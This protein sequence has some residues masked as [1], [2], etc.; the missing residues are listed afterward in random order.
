MVSFEPFSPVN[1]R[2]SGVSG[3]VARQTPDPTMKTGT[4]T[5]PSSGERRQHGYRRIRQRARQSWR[6]VHATSR[7]TPWS[8][9]PTSIEP[10][11]RRRFRSPCLFSHFPPRCRPA[12]ARSPGKLATGK[13]TAHNPQKSVIDRLEQIPLSRIKGA[14]LP[15][16]CAGSI[17][18]PWSM[19]A[20]RYSSTSNVPVPSR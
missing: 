2:D 15:H 6:G 19:S 1:R 12:N 7:D 3:S 10:L 8:V 20:I 18:T 14:A 5:A 16:P 13:L 11:Y 9:L 4:Y 17:A